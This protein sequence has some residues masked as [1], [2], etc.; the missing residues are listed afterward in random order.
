MH[1]ARAIKQD[2]GAGVFH[3]RFSRCHRRG[4]LRGTP[5]LDPTTDRAVFQAPPS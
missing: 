4:H 2:V 5:L 1:K 3:G